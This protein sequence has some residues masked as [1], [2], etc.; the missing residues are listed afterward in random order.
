MAHIQR[1][2]DGRWRARYREGVGGVE[3]SRTFDRKVDAERFLTTVEHS[4]LI[5]AYIDPTAGRITFR[6]FA[7]DW[8]QQQ[9]HRP[10][11]ATSVEQHLRLHVYPVLGNRP[12]GTIRPSEVQALVRALA[13]DLAAS[14]VQVVYGRV[15]AVFQ[16]AVRDRLIASSPCVDV[17]LPRPSGAPL[18]VLTP[19]QALALA[20]AVAPRYHACI[21]AGAG[22][23][24]RPA[25]LFGLAVD[26]ID[27]LRGSV[28]VDQQLVRARGRG[29]TLAPLKTSSSYRT[30][31]LP[32]VVGSAL[33]AHL[34]KWPPHADLGVVFTNQRSSPVQQHPFAM[35]WKTG[36][37]RAGLPAWA[38][39]H[40]LRHLYASLLIRS[41]ASVKVVQARLGHSSAKTTLD[42]YGH[43]FP[44]EEDRT[45]AAIDG[46]LAIPAASP[47][48]G[49]E[50]EMQKSWSEGL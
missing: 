39:P 31:P 11:T 46:A 24:L 27:F 2:G 21:V 50:D 42:V 49:D 45:K 17:R 22:L 9:I 19:D 20:Q 25:E 29:V 30:V 48:P 34:A 36:A 3:R 41:G 37:A 44:D 8:R 23:G 1:R 40:D 18:E 14:T 4:K 10:G 28:K 12:L 7:E 13:S 47:R 35:V 33:A 26:R 6:E 38:T 5:G 16:A 32:A 15:S 43:L